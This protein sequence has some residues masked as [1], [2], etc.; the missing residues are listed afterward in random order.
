MVIPVMPAVNDYV[1]EIQQVLRD[2]MLS[3]D[4]DISG[5][6]MQKK[7]RSAQLAQYNFILGM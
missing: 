4:V 5:N 6:T 3:V 2:Q 7:I 1:L